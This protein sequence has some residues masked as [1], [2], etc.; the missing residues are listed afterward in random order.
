MEVGCEKIALPP[1]PELALPSD[2]IDDPKLDSTGLN[3]THLRE[4]L[5]K[6]DV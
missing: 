4:Y 1:A 6:R 2:E 5:T 3:V